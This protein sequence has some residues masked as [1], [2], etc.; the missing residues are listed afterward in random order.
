MVSVLPNFSIH[1]IRARLRALG[2]LPILLG[3]IVLAQVAYGAT[4]IILP[5][6]LYQRFIEGTGTLNYA[7]L[8]VIL[9]VPNVGNFIASSPV[10]SLSDRYGKK[11]FLVLGPIIAGLS[12]IPYLYT[13]NVLI[14]LLTSFL[15]G[16]GASMFAV[17]LTA[18]I[19]DSA[20]GRQ[21]GETMARFSAVNLAGSTVGYMI[22]PLLFSIFHVY[23]FIVFLVILSIPSILVLIRFVNPVKVAVVIEQVE[24]EKEFLPGQITFMQMIAVLKQKEFRKF[25]PIWFISTTLIG[26]VINYGPI[27]IDKMLGTNSNGTV[28][29]PLLIVGVMFVAVAV[30]TGVTDLAFGRLPDKIGRK[31]FLFLGVVCSAMII[32]LLAMIVNQQPE[33]I[34]QILSDPLGNLGYPLDLNFYL[35]DLRIPVI[36][37]GIAALILLIPIALFGPTSMAVV[38]DVTKED[39]TGASMGLYTALIGAGNM[40]AAVVGGFVIENFPRPV[41]G[42]FLF[43]SLLAII[44]VA[45]MLKFLYETR[46]IIELD[47]MD[48]LLSLW[49]L[50]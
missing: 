36:F 16:C 42:V 37:F 25:V 18:F 6:Y 19:A 1:L 43:C 40:T 28:Q 13:D 15:R 35:F 47:G 50:S 10:G 24:P 8:G 20:P 23:T 14:L 38:A 17:P 45:F 32:T 30:L 39:K 33:V 21:R 34:Q 7:L 12:Y 27:L 31:P 9:V 5:F 48:Q 3:G 46:S 44:N 2:A 49:D 22:S 26:T 11:L 29:E 41:L 4:T